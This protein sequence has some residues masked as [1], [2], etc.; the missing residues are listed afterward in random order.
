MKKILLALLM[1]LVVTLSA[2]TKENKNYKF[3]GHYD[4]F[5]TIFSNSVRM[6]DYESYP[7]FISD[8]AEPHVRAFEDLLNYDETFFENNTLLY[9]AY[10][11]LDSGVDVKLDSVKIIENELVFSFSYK[12]PDAT[13]VIHTEMHL[14]EISKNYLKDYP[15]RLIVTKYQP[16]QSISE[17]RVDKIITNE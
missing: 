7:N 8:K 17:I 3:V 5:I 1:I 11:R 9:I 16:E 15:I 6:D 14:V 4:K 13:M 12:G 10:E 2:C